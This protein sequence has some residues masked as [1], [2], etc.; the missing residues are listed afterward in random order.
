MPNCYYQSSKGQR[1]QLNSAPVLVGTAE[2]LRGN[3]WGYTIGTRTLTGITREAFTVSLSAYFGDQ[4]EADT[5]RRLA[6][7]DMANGTPGTFHCGDWFQ[8]AYIVGYDASEITRTHHEEELEIV[9]L[10]GQW[11]KWNTLTLWP[12]AD[13]P[14]TTY[15]DLPVDAPFDL[16]PPAGASGITN[17]SLLPSPVRL[18]FYGPAVSPYLLIGSNRYE[19]KATIPSGSR[20]VVDGSVWPRTIQMI[21][22]EGNITDIFSAG[23]RGDGEGAGS[24]IFEKIKPGYSAIQWSGS[25]GIDV[26]WLTQEGGIPWVL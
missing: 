4:K 22:A 19:I 10:D 18:T 26:E 24:Y 13:D 2:N 7:Y 17:A 12:T 5:L 25:F 9:L 11:G 8:R 21:S 23:E 6:D 20:V 3:S 16:L 15:L 1:V 14:S